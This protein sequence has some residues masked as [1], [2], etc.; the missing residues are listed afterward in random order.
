MECN[1]PLSVRGKCAK[2]RYTLAAARAIGSADVVYVPEFCLNYAPVAKLVSRR[3]GAAF[4]YDALVSAYDTWVSDRR[5]FRATSP[6]GRLF[7]LKDWSAV[8]LAD[9]VLTDT[10]AH[11]TYFADTFGVPR[12]K[13]SVVPVGADEQ[14][15]DRASH[16]PPPGQQKTTS[17]LFYGTHIPLHGIDTIIRAAA[18]LDGRAPI[19]VTVVGGG[20]TEGA[21]RALAASLR[22]RD[23]RLLPSV[24]YTQLPALVNSAD[25]CLGV[26]GTSQKAN[27][28]VPHKV[29]QALLMGKAVVTRDSDAIREFLVPDRHLVVCEPGCP[30]ALAAAILRLAADAG[31][32]SDLGR[33]G[34]EWARAHCTSAAIGRL[35]LRAMEQACDGASAGAPVT[36]TEPEGQ[37]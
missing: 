5:V 24:P 6:T 34:H 26:F 17:V 10:D 20:Q 29:Y 8:H 33:R 35:A 22:P 1:V 15:F 25:I 21:T 37:Q 30:E 27:R 28:V 13:I 7:W 2:L 9:H 19:T 32:R 12:A 4:V 14:L 18:M 16:I 23:L 11:R 31:L 36:E 3:L